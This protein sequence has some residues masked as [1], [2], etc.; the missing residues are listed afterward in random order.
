M[1]RSL[2]GLPLI[3]NPKKITP[4]YCFSSLAPLLCFLGA[5]ELDNFPT[6]VIA[7]S[8]RMEEPPLAQ[9]VTTSI[10]PLTPPAPD[11]VYFGAWRGHGWSAIVLHQSLPV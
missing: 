3:S 1:V 10:L 11:R 5:K 8:S 7:D 2:C 4:D 6:K 9:Q